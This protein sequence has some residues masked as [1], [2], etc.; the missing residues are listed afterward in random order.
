MYIIKVF[1]D[2]L[3]ILLDTV[4]YMVGYRGNYR[5]EMDHAVGTL[6]GQNG[7]D[8]RCLVLHLGN[9]IYKSRIRDIRFLAVET[10]QDF[11][12]E[13]QQIGLGNPGY[14]YEILEDCNCWMMDEPHC[15]FVQVDFQLEMPTLGMGVGRLVVD[16]ERFRLL[17]MESCVEVQFLLEFCLLLV[18]F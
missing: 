12:F 11:G 10:K 17:R 15:W 16:S 13:L 5:F 2:C 7:L 3:G 18:F 4:G 1:N 6:A 8:I 14:H 9:Q